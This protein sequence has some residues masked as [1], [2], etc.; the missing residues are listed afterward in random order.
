MP[1][2]SGK[3]GSVPTDV[4]GQPFVEL[5]VR[6]YFP[7]DPENYFPKA[8]GTML[9]IQQNIQLQ[10]GYVTFCKEFWEILADNPEHCIILQCNHGKHRSVALAELMAAELGTT[11]VHLSLKTRPK[12][13]ESSEGFINKTAAADEGRISSLKKT[14]RYSGHV[15][16]ERIIAVDMPFDPTE[17]AA[18]DLK[19]RSNQKFDFL[20]PVQIKWEQSE[21]GA[22]DFTIRHPM[23][24]KSPEVSIKQFQMALDLETIKSVPKDT[25]QFTTLM[26]IKW[27]M[28][29]FCGWYLSQ[30]LFQVPRHGTLGKRNEA[31]PVHS[32]K[33][34]WHVGPY[35]GKIAWNARIAS[36]DFPHKTV[37]WLG[38]DREED[39]IDGSRILQCTELNQVW[40]DDKSDAH[41]QTCS[42]GRLTAEEVRIA[43]SEPDTD[44]EDENGAALAPGATLQRTKL[45]NKVSVTEQGASNSTPVRVSK[46]HSPPQ[47]GPG[48]VNS[49]SSPRPKLTGPDPSTL[50]LHWCGWTRLT[51]FTIYSEYPIDWNGDLKWLLN[52]EKVSNSIT[53]PMMDLMTQMWGQQMLVEAATFGMP[54]V[55]TEGG[56]YKYPG[57]S[58][59]RE[60]SRCGGTTQVNSKLAFNKCLEELKQ[61]FDVTGQNYGGLINHLNPVVI[62]EPEI[63]E[64]T[65]TTRGLA[66]LSPASLNQWTIPLNGSI[67]G[68]EAPESYSGGVRRAD[69]YTL[70]DEDRG[71]QEGSAA[72]A[73]NSHQA[74]DFYRNLLGSNAAPSPNKDARSCRCVPF[75]PRYSVVN[76]GYQ[77]IAVLYYGSEGR[78]HQIPALYDT[79]ARIERQATACTVMSETSFK[80]HFAKSPSS[81]KYLGEGPLAEGV[82]LINDATTDGYVPRYYDFTLHVKDAKGK[83]VPETFNVAV[84]KEVVDNYELVMGV[85]QYRRQSPILPTIWDHGNW[86]KFAETGATTWAGLTADTSSHPKY[87]NRLGATTSSEENQDS[88][89]YVQTIQMPALSCIQVSFDKSLL[90]LQEELDPD[91]LYLV[92]LG[93]QALQDGLIAPEAL[94]TAQTA[95]DLKSGKIRNLTVQVTNAAPGRRTLHLTDLFRVEKIADRNAVFSLKGYT[96]PTQDPI[97]KHAMGELGEN[98]EDMTPDV[99]EKMLD[100]VEKSMDKKVLDL[101]TRM[102]GAAKSKKRKQQLAGMVAAQETLMKANWD[103][104]YATA[105]AF[106]AQK[107]DNWEPCFDGTTEFH[108][109]QY[110]TFDNERGASLAGMSK[111]S[112]KKE[113]KKEFDA[114]IEIPLRAEIEEKRKKVEVE[115]QRDVKSQE[116]KD[117]VWKTLYDRMAPE[118]KAELDNDPALW[119]AFRQEFYEKAACYHE[120]G[121]P[122]PT[123][124][125][126]KAYCEKKKHPEWK[127]IPNFKLS[128][129]DRIRLE[130]IISEEIRKGNLE[131]WKPG[132][133]MP[134]HA[135][136][137]FI[138]ARKGHLTG[139][140]VV[141][142][143]HY[144]KQ[145][146]VPV[147]SMPLQEDILGDLSKGDSKYFGASDLATGY[148]H[149]QLA[150]EEIPFLAITTDFGVFFSKKLQL[151][152]AWA[153]SW[154]QARSASAFPRPFHVYIDDIL[155]K[156]TSAKDLLEKIKL[157]HER[158]VES[159][160]VFSLRKT[161]LGTTEVEALGHKITNTG[162]CAAESKVKLVQEWKQPTDAKNLKSFVCV[163]TYLREYIWKF[164]E[165]CY[166]LKQYLRAKDPTPFSEFAD[167]KN[168]QRAINL[169]KASIMEGATVS[170]IDRQAACDYKNT[171]RIVVA[172]VDASKYGMSFIIC[173][174]PHRD[175]PLQIA[176]YKAKSFSVAERKWSTLE[177]ELYGMKYFLEHGTQFLEGIPCVLLF[178]H[179]NMGESEL[180]QI[181]KSKIKSDKVGR[182]AEK[183]IM[184][185]GRLQIRRHY[186]PGQLNIFAD[187]GS[188]W[189]FEDEDTNEMPTSVRQLIKFLF[190]TTDEKVD[191]I[192]AL[193]K[194][195]EKAQDLAAVADRMQTLDGPEAVTALGILAKIANHRH[196]KLSRD[197]ATAVDDGHARIRTVRLPDGSRVRKED[198]PKLTKEREQWIQE[199]KTFVEERR[200][201]GT[202][203]AVQHGLT[204]LDVSAW[205]ETKR[206]PKLPVETLGAIDGDGAERYLKIDVTNDCGPTRHSWT[207]R[208][209][210][211]QLTE[212]EKQ[213]IKPRWKPYF[214]YKACPA[215][216][217]ELDGGQDHLKTWRW[218]EPTGE[219]DKRGS[220]KNIKHDEKDPKTTLA[221]RDR[222][223]REA[224]ERAIKALKDYVNT[225][226]GLEP[227]EGEYWLLKY[228]GK[229]E[230]NQKIKRWKRNYGI[231]PIENL[232]TNQDWEWHRTEI[233]DGH[234]FQVYCLA[235]ENSVMGDGGL[236]LD[237]V[238]NGILEP[239]E[240]EQKVEKNPEEGGPKTFVG[241][242][243]NGNLEMESL[244]DK[245]A[246]EDGT[247]DKEQLEEPNVTQ[248]DPKARWVTETSDYDPMELDWIFGNL[249]LNEL[250]GWS[251][252][253]EVEIPKSVDEEV[254][255][256]KDQKDGEPLEPEIWPEHGTGLDTQQFERSE[257]WTLGPTEHV[258]NIRGAIDF[259]TEMDQDQDA[260][261]VDAGKLEL[262]RYGN[263][264]DSDDQKHLRES[265]YREIK[266]TSGEKAYNNCHI[267]SSKW[268]RV[269]IPTGTV[270]K[271]SWLLQTARGYPLLISATDPSWGGAVGNV[272]YPHKHVDI[273]NTRD[274]LEHYQLYGLLVFTRP[275]FSSEAGCD[276]FKL[277]GTSQEYWATAQTRC[278][279]C[280]WKLQILEQGIT[281]ANQ[282]K[283][284][285]KH[286]GT[287]WARAELS[288]FRAHHYQI[289]EGVLM[290]DGR[291]VVPRARTA[292]VL[293][294]AMMEDE[295]LPIHAHLRTYYTARAHE[296][297]HDIQ[298][299]KQILMNEVGVIWPNMDR[300]LVYYHDH[301]VQCQYEAQLLVTT[302]YH[303]EIYDKRNL[304][305]F[306]DH[307]GPFGPKNNFYLLTVIDDGSG[308]GWIVRVRDKSAA[309]VVTV[310]RKLFLDLIPNKTPL[311]VVYSGNAEPNSPQLP[312]AIRADNGF[313]TEVTTFC[314]DFAKKYR[315]SRVTKF[316]ESTA[317]NPS[318]QHRIE[319]PHKLFR[320]WFS[321]VH[322]QL[323]GDWWEQ[324]DI[325]EE[326]QFRWRQRPMYGKYIPHECYFGKDPKHNCTTTEAQDHRNRSQKQLIA[327]LSAL[328]TSKAAARK[329]EFFKSHGLKDCQYKDGD[330]V[331]LANLL[332]RRK[333]KRSFMANFRKQIFKVV[334]T[335]E[336]SKR[337]PNR[338]FLEA[339]S[340]DL[341]IEFK[342]P[343][344]S[345]KLRPVS[346]LYKEWLVYPS[347][348]GPEEEDQ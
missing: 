331:I 26:F 153:P 198:V 99:V 306:M 302:A 188:R 248:Q 156:T 192:D 12:G 57:S 189:G 115:V 59:E 82:T 65:K 36:Q 109:G 336:S 179:K 273:L 299:S 268:E 256:P 332:Q 160:F 170:H 237:L 203:K 295:T 210:V 227:T 317:E 249:P 138:A 15:E 11:C 73:V 21:G 173:Q 180:D 126:E 196:E 186:L 177:R 325:A 312:T 338:V 171:G 8:D 220:A 120:E 10:P 68:S 321:M 58:P 200:Q 228:D 185:L 294:I 347:D 316:I 206:F 152:P 137:A 146:N 328:R 63:L 70:F 298:L 163:V 327:E 98:D 166:P 339:A 175:K 165:K 43:M 31:D 252:D 324:D 217:L 151:G 258:D 309:T 344:N 190:N 214:T 337:Y 80:K 213:T 181:W 251:V 221:M 56:Q 20:S 318:G 286:L 37:W 44:Y 230:P 74:A 48:I 66:A 297:H 282:E 85:D 250:K 67:G 100:D 76:P 35:E 116:W 202:R 311:N 271:V 128:H 2:Y 260:D 270:A 132:M 150:D 40:E 19:D 169:L 83:M 320:R 127:I 32:Q 118:L 125:L 75:V 205:K 93:P 193:I 7:F 121:C 238:D 265:I 145:I 275:L 322:P 136:P 141:D 211:E 112:Y 25:T 62:E 176:V 164:A 1:L 33:I 18:R 215:W 212:E 346:S 289:I 293:S 269:V 64:T 92:R 54:E 333:S 284:L 72:K 17:D 201:V 254:E 296:K 41:L 123:Y 29:N 267:Y 241:Q 280:K 304:V 161:F 197:Q 234:T 219:L 226:V 314:K 242:P 122:T 323:T 172:Y 49:G 330:L 46:G 348:T 291:R 53:I 86:I 232:T 28:D 342:L 16:F 50:S 157:M 329:L 277:D 51:Q 240:E 263:A 154:F 39:L 261:Q 114:D 244:D 119:Q 245:E 255:I 300:D 236:A 6:Q 102:A 167:D 61:F 285:V 142:F 276:Q 305:W 96:I 135:S 319:R 101:V 182:W 340:G 283:F 310:L 97:L 108:F 133:A 110:G 345:K 334:K 266:E 148:F 235:S 84:V 131:K 204:K 174:R 88:Q 194:D 69:R 272:L 106:T 239:E 130:W 278:S 308:Y 292:D 144:N 155:F 209:D 315:L 23:E 78:F 191:D 149:A 279:E 111:N 231:G 187:L 233:K 79:G 243:D 208:V 117:V 290:C 326:L 103:R 223:N 3:I 313:R 159:G 42:G 30:Q 257:N 143:R 60:R 139:R 94:V 246:E 168:A 341:K 90:E 259:V 52:L 183:I 9:E 253:K 218:Q 264:E 27:L 134:M 335:T 301:C 105:A 303:S 22:Q 216:Q 281:P 34:L 222:I 113:Q 45:P 124:K 262:P 38:T 81:F 47:N 55:I 14:R 287:K 288:E 162:R 140:M 24:G 225:V 87:R 184:G 224:R 129:L 4:G 71:C 207:P 91:Q 77:P 89:E 199:D 5:D 104:H 158:S 247:M 95:E 107:E 229:T 343:V 307:Q 178:D 274:V 195:T 147:F 13:T